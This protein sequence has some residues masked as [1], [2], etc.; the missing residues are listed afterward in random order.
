MTTSTT[1]TDHATIRRWTEARGGHPARVT[2][3]EVGG[4]LRID[5]G[6]PEERLEEISWETFF[7]AFEENNLAFL[8]QE[9]L[10]D[11]AISRFNKLVVR[12]EGG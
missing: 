11:G 10:E 7:E 1:T 2:G 9:K 8:Y 3:T 4:L 12:D 6:Q 5:F